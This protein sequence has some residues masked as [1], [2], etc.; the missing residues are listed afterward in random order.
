MWYGFVLRMK[1]D[2]SPQKVLSMKLKE[3][4]Q[5]E[6]CNQDRNNR[7]G[8]ISYTRKEKYGTELKRNGEGVGGREERRGERRRLITSMM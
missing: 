5:Q 8:K 6:D 4:T 1:K 2:R 3:N 7:L